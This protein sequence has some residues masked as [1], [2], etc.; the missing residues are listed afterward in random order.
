[1]FTRSAER[2]AREGYRGLKENRRIVIPGSVNKAVT[3]LTRVVPR[4]LLLRGA[5]MYQRG[6]HGDTRMG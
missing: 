6:R 1:L 3:A 5:A 2:V 4:A